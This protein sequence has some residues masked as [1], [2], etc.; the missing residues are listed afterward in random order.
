MLFCR[1][2]IL[3]KINLFEKSFR[4]IIRVS[5][6]LDPDQARHYFGPDLDPNCTQR[7]SVGLAPVYN[8]NFVVVKLIISLI[9]YSNL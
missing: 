6:R 2:L 4:N 7:L 3:F 8:V 5:N 1:L 9:N